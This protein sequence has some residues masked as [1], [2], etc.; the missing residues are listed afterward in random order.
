MDVGAAVDTATSEEITTEAVLDTVATELPFVRTGAG[1]APVA[2]LALAP[3][4]P[5]QEKSTPETVRVA[6]RFVP[7]RFHVVGAQR[8]VLVRYPPQPRAV[9][10][11]V[12]TL[13]R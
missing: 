1:A 9:G 6:W 4:C 11:A 2:A 7:G 10:V 8:L 3:A 5:S 12:Q 13:G